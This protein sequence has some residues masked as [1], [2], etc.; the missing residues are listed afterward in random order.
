MTSFLRY[1]ICNIVM[2]YHTQE[3][4]LTEGD[5]SVSSSGVSRFGS[6]QTQPQGSC[7]FFNLSVFAYMCN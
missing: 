6:G 3:N 5:K 7:T 2:G 1:D 4:P